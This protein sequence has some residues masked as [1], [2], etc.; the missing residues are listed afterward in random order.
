MLVALPA[1]GKGRNQKA[2]SITLVFIKKSPPCKPLMSELLML[3]DGRDLFP[4]VY[5]GKA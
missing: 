3:P 5:G 2:L 1:V 4:S